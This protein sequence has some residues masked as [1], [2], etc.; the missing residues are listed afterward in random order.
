MVNTMETRDICILRESMDD[1]KI[2]LKC[3][4]PS[5]LLYTWNKVREHSLFSVFFFFHMN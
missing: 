4:Q 5:Y 3:D 1:L 2:Q